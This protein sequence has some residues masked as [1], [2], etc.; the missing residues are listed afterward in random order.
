[1]TGAERTETPIQTDLSAVAA[2]TNCMRFR[3]A[4]CRPDFS[5]SFIVFLCEMHLCRGPA[6]PLKLSSVL[7]T[8]LP[9]RF[10]NR[11]QPLAIFANAKLRE[12]ALHTHNLAFT[13]FDMSVF[14]SSVASCMLNGNLKRSTAAVSTCSLFRQ[15]RNEARFMTAAPPPKK[16]RIHEK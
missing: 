12:P 3:I 10:R 13:F 1:M 11:T 4:L 6:L 2:Q 16:E 14:L 15:L 9:N 8:C 7:P 5:L